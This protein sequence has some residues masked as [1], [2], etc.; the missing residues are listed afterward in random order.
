M[1]KLFGRFLHFRLLAAS[2][3][4]VQLANLVFGNC[5][6]LFFVQPL[7]WEISVFVD[8]SLDLV[9]NGFS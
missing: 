9:Q 5:V 6:F 2:K 1:E 7:S 4:E 3:D 8:V